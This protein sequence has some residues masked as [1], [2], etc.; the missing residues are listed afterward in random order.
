MEGTSHP[1]CCIGPGCSK[2]VYLGPSTLGWWEPQ[3]RVAEVQETEVFST[4]CS[5]LCLPWLD[6]TGISEVDTE[7]PT[8]ITVGQQTEYFPHYLS[9]RG[10]EA[11]KELSFLPRTLGHHVALWAQPWHTCSPCLS[12]F[13]I[14]T[15]QGRDGKQICIMGYNC[16]LVRLNILFIYGGWCGVLYTL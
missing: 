6:Q 2:H 4:L 13:Y 8:R 1:S 14:Q 5:E 15:G 11:F 3:E 9:W 16:E 10:H 7:Q 12:Q